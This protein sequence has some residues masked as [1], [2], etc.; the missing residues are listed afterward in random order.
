MPDIE[1]KRSHVRIAA[2]ILAAILVAATVFTYLSYTAAFTSTDT[3]TVTS[4]RAGLVMESDAK[5]KYRGIQIG[6]VKA[7]EYAGNQAKLTLAIKSDEMRYIPANAVVHIAGTTVFGAK[8]VEFVPP[9][10]PSGQLRDGANVA[11]KD[12]QLEV[13]TLFQTLTDVLHKIDPINL[14]AT[15]SALAEGLRGNGDDLGA[16]L[17][18]LN[19]YLQQLKPKLP[20]LQEDFKKTAVVANIYGDAGPDLARIVDNV[21]AINHTII[22]E[23]DNL[24]ATLLA[25][26]GLANNGTATLEPAAENY[27]AAIQRLRAPLQGAAEYS[28]EFSCVRKG[29]SLA[30]D[31][32]VPITGGPK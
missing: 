3:V 20:T 28:P 2:P 4:P 31:H 12:V 27:I 5:V 9:N 26:T 24:N 32:F 7:I 15:L 16:P 1:A 17:A 14:N 30:S 29:A 19:Y 21:P 23:Q 11:A 6:E 8:S 13:N 18:G 22:D 25:A 10:Q